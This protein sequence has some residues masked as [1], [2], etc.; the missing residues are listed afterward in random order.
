MAKGKAYVKMIS[1][2]NGE[3]SVWRKWRA[4]HQSIE[5][6]KLASAAWNRWQYD[7]GEN[8]SNVICDN[9]CKQRNN[10]SG[11]IESE[12][13]LAAAQWLASMAWRKIIWHGGINQSEI[14]CIGENVG[15]AEMT[16][17]RIDGGA[18]ATT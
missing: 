9:Q 18:S 17:R 8:E 10:I 5:E 14:K 16:W 4:W 2:I 3:S 11:G 7:D 13:N 12:N 15:C 1:K 6:K